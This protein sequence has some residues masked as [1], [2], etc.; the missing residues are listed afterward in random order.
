MQRK[1]GDYLMRIVDR[2]H[3]SD[4][5]RQN[6]CFNEGSYRIRWCE[7]SSNERAEMICLK[8]MNRIYRIGTSLE[9]KAVQEYLSFS[10]K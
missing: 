4:A 10:L 2:R 5:P 1:R 7:A 6:I 8:S 3:H 9:E